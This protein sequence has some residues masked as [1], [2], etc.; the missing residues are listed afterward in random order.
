M[1]LFSGKSRFQ[2]LAH[3]IGYDFRCDKA[4]KELSAL[5]EDSR[6]GQRYRFQRLHLKVYVVLVSFF[7]S[8]QFHLLRVQ[9]RHRGLR[10]VPV[11]VR[12]SELDVL[13]RARGG[14]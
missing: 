5:V 10:S 6:S 9:K 13:V 2:V 11:H 1:H 7:L 8:G 3:V 12:V 4:A 14:D